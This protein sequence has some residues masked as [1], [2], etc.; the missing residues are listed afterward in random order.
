M[1]SKIEDEK[2]K[3]RPFMRIQFTNGKQINFGY[4]QCSQYAIYHVRG[5]DIPNTR[6]FAVKQ[7]WLAKAIVTVL[8]FIKGTTHYAYDG[9]GYLKLYKEYPE[10]GE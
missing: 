4:I 1:R 2:T 5:Y 10:E 6:L 3:A 7:E 8:R 9:E